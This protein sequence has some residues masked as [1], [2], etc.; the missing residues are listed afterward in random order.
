MTHYIPLNAP[1]LLG[2]E[3]VWALGCITSGWISHRS[4]WV[5]RFEKQ[6]ARRVGKPAMAVSSGTGA[7]W[8]A[9]KAAGIGPG[10]KVAVPAL[11]F[12]A[13]AHAVLAVGAEVVPVDVHPEDWTANFSEPHNLSI[14]VALFGRRGFHGMA[15][16]GTVIE[17]L[18]QCLE[19]PTAIA[20]FTCYSFYVNKLM[21][22]GEG[23]MVVA[24][25][26]LLEKAYPWAHQGFAN[27]FDANEYIH[28]V[29]GLNFRMTGLQAAIGCAQLDRLD[30]FIERRQA[31]AD[32]YSEHLQGMNGRGLWQYAIEVED[33]K[34]LVE[35]LQNNAIGAKRCFPSLTKLPYISH[36]TTHGTEV[37]EAKSKCPVAE[38][39][40]ERIV[41][42]PM[43]A[44]I[45]RVEQDRVIEMV[46]GFVK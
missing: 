15:P 44:R 4:D 1:D 8:V 46:Q 45:K 34:G 29:P 21:T 38:R 14:L 40:A 41:M 3:G 19:D 17:D 9:L 5:P 20:D 26:E 2:K 27:D 25:E 31:A 28:T 24:N 22:T 39:L 43:F 30:D 32:Y 11:T 16:R 7:L 13:P 6:F 12:A 42:I 37:Y 36:T 33:A 10:D 35:H 23:G 18:A